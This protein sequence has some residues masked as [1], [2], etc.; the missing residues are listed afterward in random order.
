MFT[1]APFV[2]EYW[3]EVYLIEGDL[4]IGND[5]RDRGAEN[6]LPGIYACRP[7]GAMPGS[8]KS[9]GDSLLPRVTAAA[10]HPESDAG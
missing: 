2:H 9:N 7:P 4:T 10:S 6:F 1:T 8:F 3:E 5:A